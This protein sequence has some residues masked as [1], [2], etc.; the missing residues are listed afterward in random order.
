MHEPQSLNGLKLF[1]I[2]MRNSSKKEGISGKPLRPIDCTMGRESTKMQ[3]YKNVNHKTSFFSIKSQVMYQ[4]IKTSLFVL[5]AALIGC[6]LIPSSSFG[7]RPLEVPSSTQQEPVVDQQESVDPD[8]PPSTPIEPLPP[9][10]VRLHLWDGT[11]VGGNVT[12]EQIDVATQFGSLR[13]PIANI[14]RFRP[15]L[16]SF[17]AVDVRIKKW[18]EQLGDRDF[19]TREQAHRELSRMGLQLK[20]EIKKFDDGGSAERKKH[21]AEIRQEI[22]QLLDE[23]SMS[24]S[25]SAPLIRQDTIETADF[26]IVGKIQQES[27][28]LVT[29]HGALEVGIA[30]IKMGDRTWLTQAPTLRKTVEVK[31]NSFFQTDPTTSGLRVNR[32]DRISIRADG[33]VVWSNWGSIS[34][35]PD[36]I[37]NQGQWNGINCGKLIARIGKSGK[38]IEVGRQAEFVATGSG[39]LYL[40]VAMQDNYASQ[41]GYNWPGE[42]QAKVSVQPA[43]R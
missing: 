9:T 40:A 5:L 22:E 16:D 20:S 17:P 28:T 8:G 30:D 1:P 33:K 36:G 26:T 35:T 29:K 14:V 41:K 18:V 38:N 15:G 23:D 3:R 34:S 37:T 12:F 39:V 13:I 43:S 31:G 24:D 7:Q 27:F 25:N 4:S 6:Q 10:A 32:G 11:V 21:L 19:A 42:Y 2:I